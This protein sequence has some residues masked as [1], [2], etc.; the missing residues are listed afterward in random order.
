MSAITGLIADGLHICS[1]PTEPATR[2]NALRPI[3]QVMWVTCSPRHLMPCH[4]CGRKRWAA[5]LS[6]QV[7]YDRLLVFCTDKD[8]CYK[9]RKR[10][11]R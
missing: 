6:V 11:R 4:R 5:R 10:R 9:T 1:A 2:Y 7:H 3:D 8:H